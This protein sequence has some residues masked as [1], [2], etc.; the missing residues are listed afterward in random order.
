MAV[1]TDVF[2]GPVSAPSSAPQ[3][4]RVPYVTV[5]EAGVDNIHAWPDVAAIRASL[6][7][8]GVTGPA[9]EITTDEYGRPF[10]VVE[11]NTG[12]FREDDDGNVEY[13]R[14][15]YRRYVALSLRDAQTR[16]IHADERRAQREWD[17]WNGWTWIR[18][19]LKP[20]RD[21]IVIAEERLR[22]ARMPTRFEKA[23][24][25]DQIE[26]QNVKSRAATRRAAKGG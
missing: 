12:V 13:E 24:E 11:Q 21:L 6:E 2:G 22:A 26:H 7:A 9:N 17:H 4:R 1:D 16:S 19:G 20:E 5:R 14:Q 23:G 8:A 10:R 15:P 18:R 3:E 25:A